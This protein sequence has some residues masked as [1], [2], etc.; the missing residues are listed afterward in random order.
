[1][2]AVELTGYEGLSSLR[3]VEVPAPALAFDEILI[4]VKAAGINFAELELTHGRYRA[5]KTPPFVMGFEAA[6]VVAEVGRQVTRFKPG[7][8]VVSIVTSGGFA[9][10][11]TANAD[12]ALPIPNG[13]S[14]ADATTI[15][16]QG[17]SAYTLLKFA[18]KLQSSDTVLIQAA[19]GGVGLYLVQLARVMGAKRII[20]LASSQDK[21]KLVRGLGADVTID[22]SQASWPEKVLEATDG[23]GVDLVLESASGPVGKESF[24]LLA[25]FGRVVVYGA[26]N[27]FDTLEP[28]QIQQLI[29]KNQSVLGFNFPSLRPAQIAESVPALLH[30][31]STGKLKLFAFHS[32]PLKD[33]R[34]AFELL[35]SRRTIG[36]VVLVP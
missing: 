29:Y 34:S 24:R 15:P 23:V 21:L 30:W 19:A 10:Y 4:E 35:S 31:I 33:V 20:A 28:E 27:I 36:K 13:V 6:G 7:D 9:E 16:I 22:Y 14:F 17:L 11:A 32:F 25:P 18:A 8:R 3:Y 26:K 2:N 12:F 1:M 5:P